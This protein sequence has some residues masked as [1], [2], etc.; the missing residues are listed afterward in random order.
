[1]LLAQGTA[2]I[3]EEFD[4]G[5]LPGFLRRRASQ[6]FVPLVVAE[7]LGRTLPDL[8]SSRGLTHGGRVE[9]TLTSYALTSHQISLLQRLVSHNALALLL[10]ALLPADPQLANRIVADL[11]ESRPGQGSAQMADV[12]SDSDP[13][14][15]LILLTSLQSLFRSVWRIA[16]SFWRG[17]SDERVLQF[18]A[19][20]L[21]SLRCEAL[22]ETLRTW[23][24]GRHSR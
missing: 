5:R 16:T 3:Q 17:Q 19:A 10:H 12:P 20:L 6:S 2:A 18:Q 9:I 15:F 8:H 21:A 13:N 1:V 7:F 23:I 4:S 14:P 24:S 22:Y 11:D